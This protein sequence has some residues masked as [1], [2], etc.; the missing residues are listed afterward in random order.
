MKKVVLTVFKHNTKALEFY[1]KKLLFRPDVT[2][3]KEN[4]IDYT[5]LSKK[6]EKV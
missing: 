5:I 4:H 6:V 2:D 3:P 1:K